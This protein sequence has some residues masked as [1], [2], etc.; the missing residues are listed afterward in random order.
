MPATANGTGSAPISPPTRRSASTLP[1]TRPAAQAGQPDDGRQQAAGKSRQAK[2]ALDSGDFEQALALLDEAELL[3]PGHGISY[4]AARDQVR[5][6]MNQAGPGH[7]QPGGCGTAAAR[8]RDSRAS[9]PA[10]RESR[11]W[12][13]RAR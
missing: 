13:A 5:S 7:P 2:A 6:A 11:P 1:R 12:R 3:Y 9:G 10:H 8:R 4:G